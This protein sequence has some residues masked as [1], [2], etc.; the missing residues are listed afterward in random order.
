MPSYS[1][2]ICAKCTNNTHKEHKQQTLKTQSSA[3]SIATTITT[4]PY[5]YPSPPILYS[6]PQLPTIA[7]ITTRPPSGAVLTVRDYSDDQI[8]SSLQ[9]VQLDTLVSGF[10]EGLRVVTI[11]THA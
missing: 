3:Y 10:V 9:M 8:W 2:L 7:V 1:A 4:H 11:Y 5:H 6:P